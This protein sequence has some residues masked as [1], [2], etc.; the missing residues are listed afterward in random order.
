M[1]PPQAIFAKLAIPG[2]LFSI[3]RFSNLIQFDQVP[4]EHSNLTR[5][6]FQKEK[7]L[8]LLIHEEGRIQEAKVFSPELGVLALQSMLV[9]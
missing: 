6:L 5:V 8:I 1:L 3:G 2:T 7:L 9:S 4:D